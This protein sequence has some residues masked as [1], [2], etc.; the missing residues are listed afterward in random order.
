MEPRVATMGDL[1]QVASILADAF[2]DD[3]VARWWLRD[4]GR[5]GEALNRFQTVMAVDDIP[6]GHVLIEAEGRAV[7]QWQPPGGRSAPMG[8]WEQIKLLPSLIQATGFS[9]LTRVLTTA[10]FTMGTI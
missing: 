2:Y 8:L 5:F 7:A 3:P 9:R 10:T 4:D 1:D 6:K